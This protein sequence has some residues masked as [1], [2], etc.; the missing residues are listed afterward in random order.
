LLVCLFSYDLHFPSLAGTSTNEEIKEII[1]EYKK[2]EQRAMCNINIQYEII[3]QN[4]R[5]FFNLPSRATIIF[6][7]PVSNRTVI[8]SKTADLWN[9]ADVEVPRYKLIVNGK[10]GNKIIFQII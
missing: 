3:V 10:L 8:T 4:V 2:I 9:F 5:C 7:D 6:V 1:F